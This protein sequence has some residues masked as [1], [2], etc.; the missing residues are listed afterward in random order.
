M[1]GYLRDALAAEGLAPR[2]DGRNVWCER[3]GD[4]PALLLNSHVDTVPI[5]NGWTRDPLGAEIAGGRLYG[6]GAG[7]AKSAVVGLLHAFVRAK[8]PAGRLIFAATCDEETGGEGLEKL[9]SRLPDFD[10]AVVGEPTRMRV[11]T[12]QRGLLKVRIRVKG[13]AGHASR[14]HEGINAIYGACD[15][16]GAIRRFEFPDDGGL[17]GAPSVSVTIIAGGERSNVIPGE[18]SLTIDARTTTRHD[19]DAILTRLREAAGPAGLE[20][21][22]NRFRPVETAEAEPLVR[23][24]SRALP[25]DGPV[26][27]GGVSDLFHVRHRPG[28]VVGPGEPE[29]SHQPDESI[30][31]EAVE[32]G[33]EG[34]TRLI[35]AYFE[36]VAG[37]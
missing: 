20:V 34:Y 19:N 12:A 25:G 30:A 23:A 33:V 32:T 13:R 11:C 17:L 36:E 26:R 10:A 5:G 14:P 35:E 15:V 28:I 1:V 6:R 8:I 21:L 16:V 27:F 31:V 24:A 4:G 22:S 9:A 29:Q 37:R 3:G 7:D 2:V 18:C